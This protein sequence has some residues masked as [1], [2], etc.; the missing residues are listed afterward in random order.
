MFSI[1]ITIISSCVPLIIISLNL[2]YFYYAIFKE[3]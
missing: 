2:L 1:L 3:Q